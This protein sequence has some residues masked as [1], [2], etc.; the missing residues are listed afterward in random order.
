MSNKE[1]VL[2]GQTLISINIVKEGDDFFIERSSDRQYKV[3]D[4]EFSEVLCWLANSVYSSIGSCFAGDIGSTLNVSLSRD[5][6]FDCALENELKK[7]FGTD[8]LSLEHPRCITT[9]SF[10]LTGV[11]HIWYKKHT[12]EEEMGRLF[13]VV[14]TDQ[15]GELYIDEIDKHYLVDSPR[16]RLILSTLI[17]IVATSSI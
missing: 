6:K 16:L 12:N 11:F 2:T 9:L 7:L 10:K 4:A 8:A 15:D 5:G 3:N 13:A 14:Y 1:A 17:F